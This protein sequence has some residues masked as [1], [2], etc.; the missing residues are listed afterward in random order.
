MSTAKQFGTI[1]EIWQGP[2]VSGTAGTQ[3]AIMTLPCP[4]LYSEITI[5]QDFSQIP[6]PA[7][8]R[9]VIRRFLDYFDLPTDDSRY[10]WQRKTTLIES[11]GMASSTADLV[12]TILALGKLHKIKISPNHVQDLLYGIERSDPIF[13]PSPGVYLSKQQ[14]FVKT[15]T[16]KPAFDVAYTILP[17][18]TCT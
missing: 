7:K 3:I 2:Y 13:F 18:K 6:I 9:A 1:G 10:T 14:H 11:I 17:G 12:A 4:D 8:S 16:W 15:W 5:R